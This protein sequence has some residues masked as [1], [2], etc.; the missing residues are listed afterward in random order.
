MRP[1]ARNPAETL[2]VG[3]LSHYLRL[4]VDILS[5]VI[6]GFLLTT[7]SSDGLWGVKL[8]SIDWPHLFDFGGV[9]FQITLYIYIIF[10]EYNHPHCMILQNYPNWNHCIPLR[11]WK[12]LF[13]PRF[14]FCFFLFESCFGWQFRRFCFSPRV[15]KKPFRFFVWKL[16]RMTDSR[17]TT[18]NSWVFKNTSVSGKPHPCTPLT[19]CP[20]ENDERMCSSATSVKRRSC[21]ASVRRSVRNSWVLQ[22]PPAPPNPFWEL[23]LC[24]HLWDK[25]SLG[26]LG[27]YK[28]KRDV[29]DVGLWK[30]SG[31]QEQVKFFLDGKSW[32]KELLT[33]Y[34]W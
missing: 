7:N 5:V 19:N 20:L 24:I 33:G 2:E 1:V 32:K 10:I 14:V 3:S 4:V 16:F 15:R 21:L 31:K 18:S 26:D 11:C 9:Y 29:G 27:L 6:T 13:R 25:T 17:M 12:S 23:P 34:F 22:D 28:Q 8:D 30:T